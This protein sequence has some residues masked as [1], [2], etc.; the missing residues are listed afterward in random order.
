MKLRPE[1]AVHLSLFQ[2]HFSLF[3]TPFKAPI[4][5][6]VEA[7][8]KHSWFGVDEGVLEAL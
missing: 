3:S 6:D 1:I 5:H 8:A 4:N 7:K 2:I